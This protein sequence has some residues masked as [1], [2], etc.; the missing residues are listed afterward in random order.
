M[1]ELY[2]PDGTGS[3]DGVDLSNS[4]A[5]QMKDIR[6]K[7]GITTDTYIDECTTTD[8]MRELIQNERRL[9]FAFE[10]HRFFDMR[11]W[12]LPLDEPALGVKITYGDDG[13]YDYEVYTVETRPMNEVKYY[14]L[15]LPESELQKSSAL[16][17]NMGW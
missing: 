5:A 13:G 7:A 11:R 14:F 9:E 1:N 8:Q 3:V 15:P 4:A 12:L 17:N 10:N 2:G 16:T 6:T